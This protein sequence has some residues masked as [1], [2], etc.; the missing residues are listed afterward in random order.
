MGRRT[1]QSEREKLLALPHTKLIKG[2][3]FAHV[4]YRDARGKWK[5]RCKRVDTVEEA[6][7]V[8]AEIRRELGLRGPEAFAGERMSFSELLDEYSRAKKI[9][10]WYAEPL[11]ESFGQ[12][13]I[14]TIT[15]GDICQFKAARAQTPNRKTGKPRSPSTINRELEWLRAVLLYAVRHDW[16]MRNPFSR[17]P[18]PLIRR[19]EEE[20]RYRIPAPDEERRI[21]T[22]CVGPR[23]HLRPIL[24][25][26]K[27][28]G[29]RQGALLSLTWSMVGFKVEGEDLVVGDILRIPKGPRNKKRPPAVGLT[30]RLREELSKLWQKSDKKPGTKIFGGIRSVK[31]S[32]AT[33]CRL[34]GVT[35]L[36]FHDWRHGNATDML[37]AGVEERLAMRA[38]GHT[39][40]ETHA[41]YTNVDERLAREIADRLDQLHA[42]RQPVA[43]DA[44]EVSEPNEWAN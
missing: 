10:E 37:E 31:R 13:R 3:P 32:Y 22:Q 34:A 5:A 38:T 8:I 9:P 1:H 35:D 21:L 12:R 44:C 17:G 2:K 18:A 40:A 29:L 36:H 7:R 19:S 33:A 25:A 41:I 26:A 4:C 42:A 11:L 30:A 20:S 15:Y 24:I 23:E 39:S 27:D 14:Q 6:I 28:T 43:F 16:L